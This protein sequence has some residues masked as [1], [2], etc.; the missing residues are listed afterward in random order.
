M[1]C[2]TAAI[3]IS[4]SFRKYVLSLFTISPLSQ[5]NLCLS[6]SLSGVSLSFQTMN[7]SHP[8]FVVACLSETTAFQIFSPYAS[9]QQR[10]LRFCLSVIFIIF[11]IGLFALRNAVKYWSIVK[12]READALALVFM[13]EEEQFPADFRV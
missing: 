6:L 11:F 9:L 13:V 4:T 2:G 5:S 7:Y 10:A 3:A 8:I 12:K 1:A